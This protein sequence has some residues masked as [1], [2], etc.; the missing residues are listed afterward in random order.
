MATCYFSALQLLQ[1]SIIT[2]SYTFK[3]MKR[4]FANICFCSCTMQRFD[5]LSYTYTLAINAEQMGSQQV[6]CVRYNLVSKRRSLGC[7]VTDI[8][9]PQWFSQVNLFGAAPLFIYLFIYRDSSESPGT[10]W[11]ISFS[12]WCHWLS[13]I[14]TLDFDKHILTFAAKEIQLVCQGCS[15]RQYLDPRDME[16][17]SA[18]IAIIHFWCQFL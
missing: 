15:E 9:V 4:S 13:A 8:S 12:R 14:N 1:A 10:D 3:E 6:L 11:L 7:R 5:K 16:Q 2:L 18:A 17:S